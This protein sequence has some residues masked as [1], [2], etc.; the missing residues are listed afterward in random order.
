MEI[1]FFHIQFVLNTFG[2]PVINCFFSHNFST[3]IKGPDGYSQN[4]VH[5]DGLPGEKKIIDFGTG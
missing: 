4:P 5:I 1:S 3:G 2:E